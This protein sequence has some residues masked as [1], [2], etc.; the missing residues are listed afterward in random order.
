MITPSKR[1]FNKNFTLIIA[2]Q[3]VSLLGSTLY[4]VVLVLYLKQM[5]GS[6]TVI[7][8]VE[9]LAF[10]P[11]VLLGPLAGTL[12]DRTNIKTVIVW[13]DFLR[14]MLMILLFIFSLDYFLGLNMIDTGIARFHFSSSFPLTIY[15]VFCVTLCMGI[16]DS[17][18]NTAMY[19][20]IPAILAKEHIQ[21]GNSFFQG[22]GGVL[23]MIGNA[24]GGILFSALGGAL[25]FLLNGISYLSAA[26]ACLFISVEHKNPGKRPA[27]SYRSFVG[28]VKEGFLFIWANRGLRNQTILYTLSNLLFPTVMIAL[29]FL[30]EDVMKLGNAY[31]GYLLSILTI[32]SIAGYFL[33]GLF[34]TTEK[35]NY[36]VICAIFFVEA[37]L[38]LFLSFTINIFFVFGLLSLLSFCMAVSRLINT[39]L[40]QKVIPE[41]LRGRVFGTLDSINGALAPL[42]FALSGVIIDLVNKNVL[43]IFFVIFV[44]YALLAILFVYSGSI[45]QF[46]LSSIPDAGKPSI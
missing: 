39:S 42:S 3:C 23:A 7:G 46:Y 32:S 35:Q 14:G 26:F 4:Y 44:I 22:A 28:E 45:R 21:K 33:F 16:I 8:V 12:V 9:L 36:V 2:G 18:F 6:A 29:P 1:L 43:L 41:G 13:S 30:V 20:M 17:A 10:L 11:W 25:V 24:M 19:S 27:S 34:K 31:Y 38:F 15:A 37:L 5:T 40:K